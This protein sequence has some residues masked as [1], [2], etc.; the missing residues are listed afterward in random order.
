MDQNN[1]QNNNQDITTTP[2]IA[3]QPLSPGESSSPL[4]SEP[5]PPPVTAYADYPEFGS[6]FPVKKIVSA[7]IGVILVIALIIGAFLF[8]SGSKNE[9]NAEIV[10]WGLWEDAPIMNAIIEDFQREHPHIKVKYEKQDIKALDNYVDRLRTRID[11]DTGP[12]IYRFHNS[13]LPQLQ[14]YLL[15]LSADVI[16]ESGIGK[17]AYYPVVKEDVNSRGAFYGIPIGID[18]LALF[19]NEDIFTQG[20]Y[21]IPTNWSELIDTSRQITVKDE[22]GKIKTAGVALGTFD[23]VAHAPDIISLL[24]A[25]IG[26]NLSDLSKTKEKVAESLDYYTYFARGDSKVWDEAMD[27]STLAFAKGNVAMYFGYSWDILTIRG[28]NPNLK[29]RVVP[30]PHLPQRNMTIANYW[31]E[32]IS[33]KTKHPEAA[34]AFL[35][36]LSQKETLEKLYTLQ[37]KQP[38]R[39]FGELYPRKDMAKKLEDNQLLYPFVAQAKE[40]QST[41]FTAYTYDGGMNQKLNEYLG[42]AISSIIKD[43]TSPDSAAEA[44]I[45]GQYAVFNP[46]PQNGSR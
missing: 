26:V 20:G 4:S 15:P 46:T 2:P 45:K 35:T 17:D 44:L 3:E 23:N 9:E 42:R 11:H 34:Y 32:G 38:G 8:F 10:Y 29:F 28:L 7:V 27:S 19:V 36:Y 37:A 41:P 6:G 22:E 33:K 5:P 40:A 12:D 14:G 39:G 31:I 16:K 1:N 18:S 21:K 24:M 25:Q 30:V 43:G 13:W